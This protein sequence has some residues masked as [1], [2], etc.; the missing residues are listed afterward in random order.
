[1]IGRVVTK[2]VDLVMIGRVVTEG[3]VDLVGYDR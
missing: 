3:I 2:G 1:M